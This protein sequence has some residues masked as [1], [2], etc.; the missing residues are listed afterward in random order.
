MLSP[1][2]SAGETTKSIP[3]NFSNCYNYR[4]IEAF[5]S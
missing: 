1:P 2:P 5:V 4:I 3:L